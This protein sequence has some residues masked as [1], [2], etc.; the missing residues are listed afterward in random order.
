MCKN[1]IIIFIEYNIKKFL[2]ILLVSILMIA[3][4]TTSEALG[5]L[6]A[7]TKE[8]EITYKEL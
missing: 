5:L 8:P 1:K 2:C 4:S 7:L 3:S 6:N